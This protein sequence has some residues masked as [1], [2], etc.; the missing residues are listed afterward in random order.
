MKTPVQPVQHVPATPPPAP[1]GQ[2]RPLPW[3][4]VGGLGALC[5]ALV[6]GLG[7]RTNQ[8]TAL[9]AEVES[10][11]AA[12]SAQPTTGAAPAAPATK[13]TGAPVISPKPTTGE[14]AQ[15]LLA[16][17]KRDPNDPMS[18]GKVDAPLVMIEW[19]DYRCPFCSKF[20]L[21]T[22]PA[23]QPYIDSGSLRVEFRDLVIFGDESQLAAKA[24][25]AAGNQGKYFEF[26]D[27]I[28]LLHTGQG[29]PTVGT[30]EINRAAQRI[31]L[32]MTRFTADLAD[33]AISQAVSADTAQ[34]TSLGLNATPFFLVGTTP[35]S[36]A[37]PTESFVA[38][39][40]AYGAKK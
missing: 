37:L 10:L 36:G 5:L 39:V 23:L 9:R 13:A 21:Q 31:G 18:K 33:P 35:V 4:L 19:A 30:E 1:A 34:A 26:A 8:V 24:A 40:E 17:A 14:Q 20:S 12:Q 32:D 6:M 15:K 7:W 11:K 16:L 2:G 28:W 25:R 3:I 29:H 27:Q 38:L 22:R